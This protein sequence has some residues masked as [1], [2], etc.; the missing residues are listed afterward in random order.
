M[1]NDKPVFGD[2]V[3]V[4]AVLKR[5][6][7]HLERGQG[8]RKYWQPWPINKRTGLYI[9]YRTLYDGR[10]D[11]IDS[12]AGTVFYPESHFQAALVVFSERERPA[13]VPFDKLR[14][15]P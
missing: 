4:Y 5:R 9:G 6:R 14:V 7:R 15:M 1:T 3:T 8:E 13:L 2:L 10:V 11:W 12:E